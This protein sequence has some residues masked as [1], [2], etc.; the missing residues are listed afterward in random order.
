MQYNQEW[1]DDNCIAAGNPPPYFNPET[2]RIQFFCKT[3]NQW[4]AVVPIKEVRTYTYTEAESATLS[5]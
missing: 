5:R 4:A 1:H 3:H 2:G